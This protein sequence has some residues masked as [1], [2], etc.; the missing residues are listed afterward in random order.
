M[1]AT[2]AEN[3]SAKRPG[4]EHFPVGLA[5]RKQKRRSLHIPLGAPHVEAS[6]LDATQVGGIRRAENPQPDATPAEE[7]TSSSYPGVGL[8]C[9]PGSCLMPA[10]PTEKNK[11]R[12]CVS[13][14][15][16]RCGGTHVGAA[17]DIPQDPRKGFRVCS[18]KC[19][20]LACEAGVIPVGEGCNVTAVGKSL[21]E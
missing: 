17:L 7:G 8:C 15:H 1:G 18:P 10:R 2:Q 19:W 13:V 20:R 21:L 16:D 4:D 9:E 14:Y 3:R 11:C 5:V 6:A 12:G